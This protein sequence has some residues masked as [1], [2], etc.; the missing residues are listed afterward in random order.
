MIPQ[1]QSSRYA[2]RL[3][4]V[5]QIQ[6]KIKDIH[7]LLNKAFAIAIV[8]DGVLM[9]FEA[10]PL[11]KGYFHVKNTPTHMPI[12]NCVR[13]AFPIESFDNRAVCVVSE[14]VFE[15]IEGY[16]AIFHEFVHCFQWETCEEKLK[17][18]LGVAQKAMA[19]GNI[20]WELDYPF[21]YHDPDFIKDYSLFARALQTNEAD[22]I[23][24]HRD[25]LKKTL[26]RRDCDYMIWQEWKEG[27]ARLIENR[28]RRRLDIPEN[29][30]GL[31]QP[32][33]RIS[34]YEGGSR[35]IDFLSARHSGLLDDLEGLFQRL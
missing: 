4:K 20:S 33:T 34:F 14:D 31:E 35:F 11:Q 16:A 28:I 9:I 5:F 10:D 27:F 21:P 32:F 25:T 23:R 3:R 24:R 18:T 29:H 2:Q 1:N 19:E 22:E 17:M 6:E 15:S 13:A 7:R 8:S 26:G 12:P 30:S